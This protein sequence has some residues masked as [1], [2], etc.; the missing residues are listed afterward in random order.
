MNR[1]INWQ[2]L[3]APFA[4]GDVSF[5][6]QSTYERG[7]KTMAVVVAYIDARNVADRL[8]AVCGPA[9]WAFD[10][11]PVVS[12]N[13][14]VL[15]AKGTLTI[16][17]VSKSDVGDAGTT[18]PT[19]ASVSDALKR[20]AVLWGIGRFLYDL[21]FM[22]ATPEQRGK[23]WVLPKAEE[24]RLRAMLPKPDGKPSAQHTPTHAPQPH[25]TAQAQHAPSASQDTPAPPQARGTQATPPATPADDSMSL[26][27][28]SAKDQRALADALRKAGYTT[29]DTVEA[30][31]EKAIKR[32]IFA[33]RLA[34]GAS[35][36][37]ITELA[38]VN[39]YLTRHGSKAGTR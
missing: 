20:A 22:T 21:P 13:S 8:D 30:L 33:S 15:A 14:A 16:C 19:K 25:T 34:S 17:G 35:D 26:T 38:K 27:H 4:P 11:Q 1:E 37:T 29:I 31:L 12:N 36:L 5:R 24:D 39:E 28:A 10:W 9:N 3:A 18:E 6:V 23:S 7:G 2:A 32:T